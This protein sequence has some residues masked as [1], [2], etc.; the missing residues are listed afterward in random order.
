MRSMKCIESRWLA[1]FRPT[2]LGDACATKSGINFLSDNAEIQGNSVF[3][4]GDAFENL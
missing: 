4:F 3:V 1:V 2:E